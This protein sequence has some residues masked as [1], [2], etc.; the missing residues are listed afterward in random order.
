MIC[1]KNWENT[2]AKGIRMIT[3]VP[4]ENRADRIFIR[5]FPRGVEKFIFRVIR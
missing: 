2:K 4:R 5:I 3:M 1:L